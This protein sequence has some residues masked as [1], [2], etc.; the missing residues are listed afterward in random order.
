MEDPAPLIGVESYDSHTIIVSVRE[1]IN[2]DN[3]WAA[4]FEALERIK[5]AFSD[6]NIKL[7]YSEGIEQGDINK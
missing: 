2:P 5:R 4:T 1:Y 7:A 3:Y 6:S